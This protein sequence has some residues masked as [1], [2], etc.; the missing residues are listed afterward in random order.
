MYAYYPAVWGVSRAG[1]RRC[2][3]A[4]DWGQRGVWS[5]KLME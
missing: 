2:I 3:G 1:S 5:E 4:R